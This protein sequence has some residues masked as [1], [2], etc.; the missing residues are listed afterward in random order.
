MN[1]QNGKWKKRGKMVDEVVNLSGYK[2]TIRQ[3]LNSAR[4]A[5]TI[6]STQKFI[7][8]TLQPENANSRQH[9]FLNGVISGS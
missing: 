4:K 1:S 8:V 9:T 5:G 3:E 6:P 7:S 2:T